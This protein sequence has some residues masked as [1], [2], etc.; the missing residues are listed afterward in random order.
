MAK[1][2]TLGGIVPEG[3]V[4]RLDTMAGWEPADSPRAAAIREA[5]DV[6]RTLP[7]RQSDGVRLH[8]PHFQSHSY[9]IDSN[10]E[11]GEMRL[12][13]FRNSGQQQVLGYMVMTTPESYELA[14]VVLK[15]YDLL[16]GI[17]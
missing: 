8:D 2:D 14:Q 16:E 17:K 5:A 7:T 4:K 1:D 13:I 12:V 11:E 15:N 9:R 3:L 6:L 10:K